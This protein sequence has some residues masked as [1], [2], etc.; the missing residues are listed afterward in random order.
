M[1]NFC[2]MQP[3]DRDYEFYG[4]SNHGLCMA[5]WCNST[6]IF[7]ASNSALSCT[8]SYTLLF[9]SVADPFVPLVSLASPIWVAAA[10]LRSSGAGVTV[11]CCSCPFLVPSHN[12]AADDPPAQLLLSAEP[13]RDA[14][15]ASASAVRLWRGCNPLRSALVRGTE[16]LTTAHR[17]ML[18]TRILEASS[19]LA[20]HGLELALL[21]ACF[22]EQECQTAL[23]LH[24]C[25]YGDAVMHVKVLLVHPVSCSSHGTGGLRL[26]HLSN[27]DET[28]CKL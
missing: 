19:P 23:I 17:E 12:Q 11:K 25:C 14:S 6:R 20:E 21:K 2:S 24:S 18:C 22:P 8:S 28:F 27:S 16:A 10:V 5:P 3:V 13:S 9:L 7:P 26:V 15:V 4:C 1:R